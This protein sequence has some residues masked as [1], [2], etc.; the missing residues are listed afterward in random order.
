MNNHPNLFELATAFVYDCYEFLEKNSSGEAK[1]SIDKLLNMTKSQDDIIQKSYVVYCSIGPEKR[2]D[3]SIIYLSQAYIIAFYQYINNDNSIKTK[4]PNDLRIDNDFVKKWAIMD[5]NNHLII[6][7]DFDFCLIYLALIGYKNNFTKDNNNNELFSF[8][9]KNYKNFEKILNKYEIADN[10]KKIYEYNINLLTEKLANINDFVIDLIKIF[11]KNSSIKVIDFAQSERE[12]NL[13]KE[14]SE[15]KDSFFKLES[16][17]DLLT[18]NNQS[19]NTQITYLK[20]NDKSQKE[21]INSLSAQLKIF[22]NGN[23]QLKDDNKILNDKFTKLEDKS[24]LQNDKITILEN[25]NQQLNDKITI[26]EN[27]NQQLKDDN[28]LLNEKITILENGSQQLKDKNQSLNDEIETLKD[29]NKLLDLKSTIRSDFT[30][31]K[32]EVKNLDII[33][34]LIITSEIRTIIISIEEKKIE[35]IQSNIES[36][37]NII[38]C[39]INPYNLNLWRK[40]SNVIL[41]NIFVILKKKEYM[42]CQKVDKKLLSQIKNL[43]NDT[44]Y[45]SKKLSEKV[46]KYEKN[47]NT[48]GNQGNTTFGNPAADQERGFTLITI[49]KDGQ[50]DINS[51]LS[52]EFLFYLKEMG[53]MATHFNEKMLNFILFEDINLK[54]IDVNKSDYYEEEKE[55]E[56]KNENQIMNKKYEGKYIFKGEE[57]INMLKNPKDYYRRDISLKEMFKLTFEKINEIKANGIYKENNQNIKSLQKDLIYLL[58]KI[59]NLKEICENY[60]GINKID[61]KKEKEDDKNKD[62]ILDIYW[63]IRGIETKINE[64]INYYQRIDKNIED[65]YCFKSFNTKKIDEMISDTNK[66]MKSRAEILKVDNIFNTFKQELKGKIRKNPYNDYPEIFNENNINK[67][68]INDFYIFLRIH[69]N[70]YSFSIIKSDVTNFNLL[71]ETI[72]NL[73]ELKDKYNKDLDVKI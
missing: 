47:I 27:D 40:L 60:F 66:N 43:S 14:F 6:S 55:R 41:K 25:D 61:Y 64:K 70:D 32:A 3:T 11:Q 26:L 33:E 17:Y 69:L 57:I 13:S 20:I 22:V 7:K 52:I 35:F 63:N 30:A 65:I 71:V 39:L 2:K 1:T 15:M 24:K 12:I 4:L 31:I 23:Q 5:F 18:K 19:L 8:L 54:E 51:S 49:K 37:K 28:K 29:N 50:Y 48:K 9:I 34:N 56:Y 36:L 38:T 59:R 16:K 62:D 45:S 21:T 46:N 72:M 58:D 68:N 73:N 10:V 67:F 44:N 53:N 42:I